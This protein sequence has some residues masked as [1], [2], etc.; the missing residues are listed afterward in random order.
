MIEL[1]L[2]C[3]RTDEVTKYN[4]GFYGG[5]LALVSKQCTKKG[6]RKNPDGG[7]VCTFFKK[8]RNISGN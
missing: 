1:V 6:S 8:F 4:Y 5:R 7:L 3:S 2:T